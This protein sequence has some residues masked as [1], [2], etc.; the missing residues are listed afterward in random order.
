MS[1]KTFLLLFILFVSTS[2]QNLKNPEKKTKKK[3]ARFGTE[4]EEL[5]GKK[6]NK[7]KQNTYFG[8][9][10]KE[11]KEKRKFSAIFFLSL[12]AV[13]I[14]RYFF[15]KKYFNKKQFEFNKT[16]NVKD[17][18]K[19]QVELMREITKLN[20]ETLIEKVVQ[21]F[22]GKYK[23]LAEIQQASKDKY[24]IL[25]SFNKDQ[26]VEFY[27]S[28]KYFL[29]IVTLF[30][31]KAIGNGNI[32]DEYSIEPKVIYKLDA[33]GN[34]N[35]ALFK[36]IEDM[37]NSKSNIRKYLRFLKD[38]TVSFN[39]EI[40]K[41]VGGGGI[42]GGILGL[43][44]KLLELYDYCS[45]KEKDNLQN[46]SEEKGDSLQ[47]KVIELIFNKYNPY[48][49][50]YLSHVCFSKKLEGF[51]G[52][53]QGSLERHNLE[54]ENKSLMLKFSML[55]ACSAL[56]DLRNSKEK[57]E[58]NLTSA[59]FFLNILN[60]FNNKY[61]LEELIN[62]ECPIL[63]KKMK[64]ENH[65]SD[66]YNYY[67]DY[68]SNTDPGFSKITSMLSLDKYDVDLVR[69][70]ITDISYDLINSDTHKNEIKN[71]IVKNLSLDNNLTCVNSSEPAEV[72]II[73]K[74][75]REILPN[76]FNLKEKLKHSDWMRRIN[77]SNSHANNNSLDTSSLS[78]FISNALRYTGDILDIDFTLQCG[79]LNSFLSKDLKPYFLEKISSNNR[80]LLI[81]EIPSELTDNTLNDPDKM[82]H[83]F[84]LVKSGIR[85]LK[86][87]KNAFVLL[88]Y[89]L[90]NIKIEDGITRSEEIT[91]EQ[92][93]KVILDFAPNFS[94][95]IAFKKAEDKVKMQVTKNVQQPDEPG[96]DINEKTMHIY[97]NSI[98]TTLH[99]RDKL[100][101][102]MKIDTEDIF[103][104]YYELLSLSFIEEKLKLAFDRN[105]N[106]QEVKSI[107]YDIVEN[108]ENIK[109]IK[110]YKDVFTGSLTKD[111]ALNK[112]EEKL[113]DEETKEI[114]RKIL[115]AFLE[116]DTKITEEKLKS[117][118]DKNIK[119]PFNSIYNWTRIKRNLKAIKAQQDLSNP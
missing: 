19:E 33:L 12:I 110:E 85:S 117:V 91:N 118:D 48:S 11:L 13:L 10:Q 62:S 58:E 78:G 115:P 42:L 92:I 67:K 70:L 112:M 74:N 15:C 7:K 68:N 119:N 71:L 40:N 8:T 26:C 3:V 81:E 99:H 52:F 83:E 4:K 106:T 88:K 111:Q 28:V 101:T 116:F 47:N 105:K 34:V 72:G 64:K 76:L 53:E 39:R 97:Y 100:G 32:T 60:E 18:L 94:R 98:Y 5:K 114:M 17:Q 25:E 86:F 23:P 35:M 66:V 20:Q 43:N 73:E 54:L 38:G 96:K 31:E 30:L 36:Y 50:K 14:S 69:Q 61:L 65:Y 113:K 1:K 80:L 37:F 90:K 107:F 63:L 57:N 21:D 59:L 6:Q 56:V 87:A 95:N 84:L 103:I 27:D 77:L 79:E 55:S 89:M 102:G 82:L 44:S 75:L 41:A 45:S 2:P 24:R 22:L 49:R 104:L 51:K 109:N 93:Y 29:Q 16:K 108:I 9:K 46:S